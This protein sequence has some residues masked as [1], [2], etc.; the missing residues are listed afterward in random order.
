MDVFFI[1]YSQRKIFNYKSVN[2]SIDLRKNMS[3]THKNSFK[4]RQIS[5]KR[6]KYKYNPSAVALITHTHT[7]T[8]IYT[9]IKNRNEDIHRLIYTRHIN[10][11]QTSKSNEIRIKLSW[12]FILIQIE[13][14]M[15]YAWMCT[16]YVRTCYLI[17]SVQCVCVCELNVNINDS[18]ICQLCMCYWMLS[19]KEKKNCMTTSDST[20][21]CLFR[22]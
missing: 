17:L 11:R 21:W 10:E 8:Y 7:R 6:Q 15:E 9:L 1:N 18:V 22:T 12:E 2:L 4:N 20:I 5:C 3:F 14:E 19:K 13:L 16:T